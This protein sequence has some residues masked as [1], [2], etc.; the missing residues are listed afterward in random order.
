MIS[1]VKFE[2]NNRPSTNVQ[3]VQAGVQLR[4]HG[5]LAVAR[6]DAQHLPAGHLGGDDVAVGVELHRSRARRDRPRPVA[7]RRL[8]GRCA[9]SRWRPS[10]GSTA[11]RRGRPPWR[12][13]TARSPAGPAARRRRGRVPS[14]VRPSRH[15]PMNSRPWCTVMPL[16][17]GR[18]S[19]STRVWPS[20]RSD[21]DP[22]VHHL[23]GVQRAVGSKA[24]SSG[25]TM[26]PPL[27]LIG[28]DLAGVDVE[29]A[30]LAAGHLRDVDAAVGAG[31]Q[32]VGAEQPAGWRCSASGASPRRPSGGAA[33]GSGRRA[34]RSSG[35]GR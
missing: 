15:S 13:A 18:S 16:A 11:A 30:D 9:R 33:R 35:L 32:T 19:R 24:T 10:P 7:A 14:A 3:V 6:I 26:S 22:A 25:A 27:A 20:C 8:R 17:Q 21:A 28:L 31:A 1:P 34:R 4:Q 29:R 2:T 12:W 23:G 5:L